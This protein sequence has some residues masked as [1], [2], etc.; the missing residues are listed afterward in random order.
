MNCHLRD[1]GIPSVAITSTDDAS[2]ETVWYN[3]CSYLTRQ[4][5]TWQY[6]KM[7]KY[8]IYYYH[9][10]GKELKRTALQWNALDV[11]ESFRYKNEDTREQ[12][13]WKM[14]HCFYLVDLIASSILCFVS[15]SEN[16]EKKI[17]QALNKEQ[18]HVIVWKPH[19]L[20]IIW[21]S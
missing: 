6:E 11:N 21:I 5:C 20:S 10:S 1:I 9:V 12:K 16:F 19:G 14:E 8:I 17:Y 13:I 4:K 18:T 15:K 2:F 7:L 3:N